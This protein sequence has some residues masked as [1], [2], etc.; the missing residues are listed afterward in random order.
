MMRQTRRHRRP[1]SASPRWIG[2]WLEPRAAA[3][4]E[5]LRRSQR[6]RSSFNQP[7][8]GEAPMHKLGKAL[9]LGSLLVAGTVAAQSLY[10]QGDGEPS[11]SMMGHGMMRGGTGEG[12]MMGTMKQMSE[13][14]DHCS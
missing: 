13:M 10:A 5:A 4:T 7:M 2:Q 14:T 9:L 8:K 6:K 12:G 3:T 11:G 1:R